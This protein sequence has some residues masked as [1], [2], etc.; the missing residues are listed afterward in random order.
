MANLASTAVTN[1]NTYYDYVQGQG[2]ITTRQLTL[3]LTGQGDATDKILASVLGLSKIYECS[4]LVKDDNT[5]IIVAAPSADGT[6]LLLKAAGTNA[7][8]VNAT[9]GS[10]LCTVRGQ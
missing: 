2:K 10:Y 7:P 9:N 4:P 6:F 8:A 1:R 5:L 3:A